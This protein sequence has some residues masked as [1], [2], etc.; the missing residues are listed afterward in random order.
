MELQLTVQIP[1]I[2]WKSNHI[3]GIW[4]DPAMDANM[5]PSYND[6]FLS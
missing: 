1:H 6:E 5:D 2:F 4:N 3:S